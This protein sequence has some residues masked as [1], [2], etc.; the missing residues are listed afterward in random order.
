MALS[1]LPLV[2]LT[3]FAFFWYHQISESGAAHVLPN[4]FSLRASRTT[5][6]ADERKEGSGTFSPPPPSLIIKIRVRISPTA[7]IKRS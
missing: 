5:T 2:C 7:S 6:A 3:L 1:C 4:Y